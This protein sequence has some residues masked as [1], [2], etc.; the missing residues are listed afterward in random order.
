MKPE[1]EQEYTPLAA[2]DAEIPAE[3]RSEETTPPETA[4]IVEYGEGR[5][6][7]HSGDGAGH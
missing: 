3:P 7:R 4:E 5:G 1:S 6:P 2:P